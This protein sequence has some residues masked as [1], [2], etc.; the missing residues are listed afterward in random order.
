[1][2]IGNPTPEIQWYLYQPLTQPGIW[3]WPPLLEPRGT[4]F[5]S[6][7]QIWYVG[8]TWQGKY[9]SVKVKVPLKGV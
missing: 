4:S 9:E 6:E 1:M 3:T 2:L 7:L 8:G 5:L